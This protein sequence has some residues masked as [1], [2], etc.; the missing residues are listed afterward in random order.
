MYPGS[1]SKPYQP[2]ERELTDE[3]KARIVAD[4]ELIKEQTRQ[5]KAAADAAEANTE[6][7]RIRQKAEK[8]RYRDQKV[9]H[10]QNKLRLVREMDADRTRQIAEGSFGVFQF[11]REVSSDRN[12]FF[13]LYPGTVEPL[14]AKL[15]AFSEANGGGTNDAA[16]IELVLNSPGGSV[17]AGWRLFGHL[18]W[19]SDVKGHEITTVVSGMAASMGG[20]LAQ[21]GDV[22]LIDA[23]SSIMIHEASSIAWGSAYELR[24]T[25]EHLTKIGEQIRDLYVSRSNGKTSVELFDQKWDRRDWWIEALEALERGFADRIRT[26]GSLFSKIQDAISAPGTEAA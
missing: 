20:V 3:E 25:A 10:E 13:G 19:L 1:G 18:R 24:D 16:K 11:N 26:G 17:F 9:Y 4:T 2:S 6:G 8:L 14:I 15:T 23:G 21:A 5:A 22:R 7:A 12:G